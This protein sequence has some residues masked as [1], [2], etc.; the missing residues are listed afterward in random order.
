M[1]LASIPEPS[2]TIWQAAV[3]GA[4]IAGLASAQNLA[5][6]GKSVLVLEKSRGVGGRMATRRIGETR[7]DHGAQYFTARHPLVQLRVAEWIKAGIIKEW[8]TPPESADGEIRMVAPGGMSSLPKSMGG[9]LTMH[10]NRT[11]TS[12]QRAYGCWQISTADGS[13][14]QSQKLIATAPVPQTLAMLDA[15][16][17]ALE[18]PVEAALKRVAYH[19]CL[20]VM[21]LLEG[22]SAM[23]PPGGFDPGVE[24]LTWM[25]DNTLKGLN[26]GPGAI[27]LHAN[28]A[29]SLEHWD[30]PPDQVIRLMLRA[31]HPWLGAKPVESQL[32]RW[33]YAR[34]VETFDKPC[35]AL[36]AP[37]PLI[38]A[39]DAFGGPRVEGAYLS[40]CMAGWAA[41]PGLE[42]R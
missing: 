16:G 29:F 10:F 36:E 38:F 26:Q 30:T 14:Y 40:G 7:F 35:L 42:P 19:R 22:P 24:P 13:R 9:G 8:P 23:P 33:R 34:P 41:L 17:T 15:G 39:G 37:G 20:A 18:A 32:H 31:A 11:V 28:P 6:H 27:T 21:A 12:I 1:T 4:G 2:K 5:A 25:A 3:I